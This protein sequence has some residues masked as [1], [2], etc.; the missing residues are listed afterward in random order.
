MKMEWLQLVCGVRESSKRFPHFSSSSF[1]LS[2]H[3]AAP[4]TSQFVQWSCVD[5]VDCQVTL[6]RL[7]HILNDITGTSGATDQECIQSNTFGHIE[8]FLLINS[9]HITKVY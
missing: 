4:Q 3:L 7:D 5:L 2:S 8:C 6:H 9:V 1:S